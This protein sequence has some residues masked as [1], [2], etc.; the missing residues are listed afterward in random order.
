M[1]WYLEECDQF[2]KN[3]QNSDCYTK[4]VRSA[5]SPSPLPVGLKSF[6]KLG[7]GHKGA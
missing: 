6:L 3:S 5:A 2:N 4:I 7:A 1:F